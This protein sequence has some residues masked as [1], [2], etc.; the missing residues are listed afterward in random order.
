MNYY[1]SLK[2]KECNLNLNKA[3]IGRP[4]NVQRDFEHTLDTW[5]LKK[6]IEINRIDFATVGEKYRRLLTTLN[7]KDNTHNVVN[8]VGKEKV[9]EAA[10]LFKDICDMELSDY[11]FKVLAK[12][13]ELTDTV[14]EAEYNHSSTLTGRMKIVKGTNFLTMKKED[15]KSLKVKKDNKLIEID[16]KSCEPSLLNILIGNKPVDDV[17]S[18]FVEDN[19]PRT[20]VKIAVISSLYG[21]TISRVSKISGLSK[22]TIKKIHDYF[23]ISKIVENLISVYEKNGYFYNLYGRPIYE[24]A[25]PMNYWLQS[26]AADFCCLAFKNLIEK[27]SLELRAVIHDAIIVEVDELAYNKMSALQEITDPITN[28]SLRVD[29]T[30]IS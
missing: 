12:R 11:Y 29:N 1:K 14:S 20:K 30:L 6:I 4:V 23:Q 5:M 2:L 25:S 26:S 10:T 15:R 19:V 8:I 3:V 9:K 22:P 17:Y 16:V 27:E 7:V 24:I 18:L 13:Y 28:I 21:S